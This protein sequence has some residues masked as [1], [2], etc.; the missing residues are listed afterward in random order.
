ME[1]AVRSLQVY[2]LVSYVGQAVVL[3]LYLLIIHG[4]L[5]GW[6]EGWKIGEWEGRFDWKLA[7][8]L[9]L[10]WILSPV[11]FPLWL[12]SFLKCNWGPNRS[13]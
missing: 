12:Y 3:L 2:L 4:V 13:S 5:T 10:Y 1:L 9:L 11:V 6:L 7:G 8:G